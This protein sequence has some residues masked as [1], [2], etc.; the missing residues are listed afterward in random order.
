MEL[1]CLPLYVVHKNGARKIILSMA[2]KEIH[3][4]FQG[5]DYHNIQ[6]RSGDWTQTIVKVSVFFK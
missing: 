1:P 5:A 6:I 3:I 2:L 4:K